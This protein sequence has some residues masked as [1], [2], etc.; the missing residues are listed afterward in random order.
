MTLDYL[1][2]LAAS[3]AL[4]AYLVYALVRPERF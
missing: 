1:L 4:S 3:V 2:G